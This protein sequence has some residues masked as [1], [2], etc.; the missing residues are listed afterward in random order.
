MDRSRF[1][2]RPKPKQ[3][4][5]VTS[6]RT[7]LLLIRHGETAWNAVRRLQNHLDIGLNAEGERQSA[8]TRPTLSASK[9]SSDYLAIYNV[10]P[11]G[12]NDPSNIKETDAG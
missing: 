11:H 2:C 1:G 10:H 9:P 6:Q 12:T 8:N 4:K 3:S 7:E 5:K